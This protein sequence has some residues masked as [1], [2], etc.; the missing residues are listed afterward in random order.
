MLNDSS[1]QQQPYTYS[2]QFSLDHGPNIVLDE[3]DSLSDDEMIMEAIPEDSNVIRKTRVRF[4]DQ[5]EA[6]HLFSRMNDDPSI[7]QSSIWPT[8]DE[9]EANRTRNSIEF[10]HEGGDWRNAL[11]EADNPVSQR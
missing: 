5:L 4:S 8:E 1:K 7:D 11:E 10:L 6:V 3:E 9:N 2:P